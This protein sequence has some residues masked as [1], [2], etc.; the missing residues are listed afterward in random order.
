VTFSS[1]LE[2]CIEGDRL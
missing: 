2:D 1:R